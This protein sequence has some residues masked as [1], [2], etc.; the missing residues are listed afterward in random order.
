MFSFKTSWSRNVLFFLQEWDEHLVEEVE[1]MNY[2]D[3]FKHGD[4]YRWVLANARETI[5]EQAE[6]AKQENFVFN[7]VT[8]GIEEFKKRD[9]WESTKRTW[10]E[11]F[12]Q[13]SFLE[14]FTPMQTK[15]GCTEFQLS[16]SGKDFQ[17][18]TVQVYYYYDVLCFIG[19][20]GWANVT[21]T[22]KIIE[23]PP[24][25]DCGTENGEGHGERGLCVPG[26]PPTTTVPPPT[27][28]PPSVE[29]EEEEG[30]K[31]EEEYDLILILTNGVGGKDRFSILIVFLWIVFC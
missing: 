7:N 23:G 27:T 25:S 14:V 3:Q 22:E 11:G 26:P 5:P 30:K 9:H 29:V 24:G 10:L 16:R 8:G 21:T 17:T 13:A 15:L 4:Y 20:H 2:I 12:D 6:Q 31:K 19:P 18:H 1:K 28:P